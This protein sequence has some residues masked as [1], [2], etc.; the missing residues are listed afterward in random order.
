MSIQAAVATEMQSQEILRATYKRIAEG[1]LGTFISAM[2]SGTL[3]A[4]FLPLTALRLSDECLVV[5]EQA[6]I[7]Y[8][9]EIVRQQ[10]S[11]FMR[12]VEMQPHMDELQYAMKSWGLSFGSFF[13]DPVSGY[14]QNALTLAQSKSTAE[15]A[16]AL[17]AAYTRGLD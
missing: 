9:G 17:M 7:E 10:R 2:R 8:V 1:D 11:Y 15:A 12:I 13:R 6:G 16:T 5:L 4:L 14:L 3:D